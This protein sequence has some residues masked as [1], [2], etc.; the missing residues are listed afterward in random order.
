MEARPKPKRKL[1]KS[2]L[3]MKNKNKKFK[4]K[5]RKLLKINQKIIS[6][7]KTSYPISTVYFKISNKILKKKIKSLKILKSS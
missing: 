2:M 7:I 4:N 1:M 6:S 3:Q 5:K